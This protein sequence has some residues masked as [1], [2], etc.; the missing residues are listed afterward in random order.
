MLLIVNLLIKT[1]STVTCV[2][3]MLEPSMFVLSHFL[4]K[5]A[6]LED[7]LYKVVELCVL[8]EI[9]VSNTRFEQINENLRL[10]VYASMSWEPVCKISYFLLPTQLRKIGRFTYRYVFF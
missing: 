9:H 7:I 10:N 3:C 6:D 2:P 8:S 4:E 5:I 1:D